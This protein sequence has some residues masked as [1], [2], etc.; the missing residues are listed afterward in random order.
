MAKPK[1]D[2]NH[3][4]FYK[5]IREAALNGATDEQIAVVLELT[6]EVFSRMKAGRYEGW[7]EKQNEER[8]A[9]IS[10]VLADARITTNRIVRAT[11]LTTILGKKKLKNKSTVIRNIRTAEGELTGA[12]EIQT[13]EQEIE[14]APSLQGMT[15]WLHHHDPEWRKRSKDMDDDESMR[16]DKSVPIENWLADNSDD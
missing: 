12:Q 6:P 8:G 5:L 9:K 15:T 11:Y 7:N 3:E 4:D 14:M 1:H 16:S 13:T 10:Q 2:Y